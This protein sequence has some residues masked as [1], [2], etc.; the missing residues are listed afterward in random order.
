MAGVGPPAGGHCNYPPSGGRTTTHQGG[1]TG[2]AD[3]RTARRT[4]EKLARDALGGTLLG[5]ARTISRAFS[6]AAAMVPAASAR[7]ARATPSSPAAPSRVPPRASRASFSAV[8]RAVRR[9]AIPTPCSLLL[10]YRPPEGGR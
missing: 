4:A 9:S 3:A 1:W 2:M 6:A 10:V 8:R 5:A 7:R